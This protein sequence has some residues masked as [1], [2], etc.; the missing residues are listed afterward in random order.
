MAALALRSSVLARPAPAVRSSRTRCVVVRASGAPVDLSKKV[1]EAV[2]DADEAC[3]KGT[4]Q[5][6]GREEG[7]G[8]RG[9]RER[10]SSAFVTLSL[11]L[12]VGRGA[13]ARAPLAACTAC[14]AQRCAWTL[15]RTLALCVSS[16]RPPGLST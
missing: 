1:E 13:R 2:K 4:T 15:A 3:A 6:R 8:E 14:S 10:G 11:R 9:R 7:R 5:V 12:V 16:A